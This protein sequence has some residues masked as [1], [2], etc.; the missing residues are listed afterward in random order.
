MY[1]T[2]LMVFA[3]DTTAQGCQCVR[4]MS[5]AR[6]IDGSGPSRCSCHANVNAIRE[7]ATHLQCW[8]H[9]D[10]TREL[11]LKQAKLLVCHTA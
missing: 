4:E 2:A 9:M 6:L 1:D 5:Y 7:A 3:R 8:T 11:W 10:A